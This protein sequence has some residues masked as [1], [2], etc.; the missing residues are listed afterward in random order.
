MTPNFQ[1]SFI[2]KE[3]VTKEVFVKKKAGVFGILAVSLFLGSI[4]IAIGMYVYKGIIKNDIQ[5]LESQLS[6]DEKTIDK[7]TIDDMSQFS[8]RLDVAKAIVTR[9]QVISKFLDNLASSTASSVQFTSFSYSDLNDGKLTVNLK[10][11]ADSYSSV[12]LQEDVLSKD[13]YFKSTLFSNLSLTGKGSV[14]FDLVA[15]VDQGISTYSP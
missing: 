2:P 9:H 12:A 10:G 8:K 3:P 11:I 5:N 14:T 4:V 15:S 13:K 7:K 1:S 6:A